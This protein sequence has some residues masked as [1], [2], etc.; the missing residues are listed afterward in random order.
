VGPAYIRFAREATP[1]VTTAQSPFRFGVAN[2][3]RY[4]GARPRF[5]DAFETLL[6]TDCSGE[7][8]DATIVAP[9]TYGAG[10]QCGRR[11]C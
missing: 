5:I 10:S 2:I 11:G 1:V 8:E 6:S 7:G 4:R 3:I 9:R